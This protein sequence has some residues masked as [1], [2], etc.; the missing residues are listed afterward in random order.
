VK[1]RKQITLSSSDSTTPADFKYSISGKVISITYS[2]AGS[3]KMNTETVTLNLTRK[4][5]D[6]ILTCVRQLLS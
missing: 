3:V 1:E 4:E 5:A 2:G 6:L